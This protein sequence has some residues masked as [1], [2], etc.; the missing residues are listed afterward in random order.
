MIQHD[1]GTL[2]ITLMYYEMEVYMISKDIYQTIGP[3]EYDEE[4][5]AYRQVEERLNS[6]VD[7]LPVLTA[8]DIEKLRR[9]LMEK[10]SAPVEKDIKHVVS[11]RLSPETIKKARALGDGYTSIL[12]RMI[13][14]SLND[15]E[16][17][18]KCLCDKSLKL[19]Q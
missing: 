1:P 4:T 12:A 7:D 8:D 15:P 10:R 13:E 11:I 9:R 2:C 19:R 6:T 5:E 17:I 18:K 16:M 14:H 3:D